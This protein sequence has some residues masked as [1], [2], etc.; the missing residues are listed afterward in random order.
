MARDDGWAGGRR[1]DATLPGRGR[2][3]P[4]AAAPDAIRLGG[5]LDEGAS[6]SAHLAT[7]RPHYAFR[8]APRG[9]TE[10]SDLGHRSSLPVAPVPRQF[11]KMKLEALKHLPLSCWQGTFHEL[12]DKWRH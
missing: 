9:R 4:P 10:A 7:R 2:V 6:G 8:R 1:I 5:P 11:T 3:T 12:A